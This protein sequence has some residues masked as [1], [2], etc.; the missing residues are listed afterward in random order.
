ML[1]FL[2]DR[3]AD[4]TGQV[5]VSRVD[6][7]ADDATTG[8]AAASARVDRPADQAGPAAAAG[9]LSKRTIFF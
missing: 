3:P 1:V 6:R 2:V 4:A 5:A 9:R 8:Q 7:P